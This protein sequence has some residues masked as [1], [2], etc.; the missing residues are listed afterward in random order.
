[1]VTLNAMTS[2]RLTKPAMVL[3]TPRTSMIADLG[4]FF[5]G[6]VSTGLEDHSVDQPSQIGVTAATLA[7]EELIEGRTRFPERFPEHFPVILLLLMP[8]C[9]QIAN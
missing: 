4:I 3:A 2:A 7:V 5:A 6:W 8:R 1:M 9:C